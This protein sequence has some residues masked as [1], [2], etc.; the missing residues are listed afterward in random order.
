MQISIALTTYNGE[1]YLRGQ[2][3][4]LL[5]QSLAP[6][7]CVI[8]DDG[9]TDGTLAILREFALRAPF[10]VHIH[11]NPERLGYKENFLRCASLCAG[12]IIAFCDQDDVWLASKLQVVAQAFAGHPTATLVVHQGQVVDAQLRATGDFY[13]RI[14]EAR[15]M[16]KLTCEPMVN[17]PGFA[18]TFKRTLLHS[19]PWNHRPTD[20]NTHVGPAAHDTWI[21]FIAEIFGNVIFIPFSLVQ[22]RRHENNTTVQTQ[23]IRKPQSLR[24]RLQARLAR[25]RQLYLQRA[26]LFDECGRLLDDLSRLCEPARVGDLRNA[27]E[28]YRR[29]A[30]VYAHRARIY[31]PQ[32]S[33]RARLMALRQLIAEHA[34]APWEHGGVSAQALSKDVRYVLL[35]GVGA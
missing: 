26:G 27:A 23:K 29:F 12:E 17:I 9:S 20:P 30:G 2:L 10:A 1:K 21:L 5:A 13:P 6:C 22:Y 34:Y 11:T 3:D 25:M 4:S 32:N 33:L 16:E 8:C 35:A 19:C 18:M 28:R 31:D 14:K 7:E 24:S 15:V